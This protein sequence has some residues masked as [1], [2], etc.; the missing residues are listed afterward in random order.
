MEIIYLKKMREQVDKSLVGFRPNGSSVKPVHIYS[1]AS[2]IIY[3]ESV[4]TQN[5]KR[6]SY[7][8]DAKG[9]TPKN[10]TLEK[11][12]ELLYESDALERP[13]KIL[14]KRRDMTV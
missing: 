13:Q 5:I 3:G 6:L 11:V 7:V 4:N 9:K 14:C 12:K 8:S 1:G 2:R 10:N